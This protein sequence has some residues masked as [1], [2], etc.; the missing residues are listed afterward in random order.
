MTPASAAAQRVAEATEVLERFGRPQ[1]IV[2]D[3]IRPAAS[4]GPCRLLTVHLSSCGVPY[5]NWR[6]SR[7]QLR[8]MGDAY[9]VDES[10]GAVLFIVQPLEVGEVRS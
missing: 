8:D 5:V 3:H 10:L 6:G 4:L 1:V 9:V 7:V 2:V